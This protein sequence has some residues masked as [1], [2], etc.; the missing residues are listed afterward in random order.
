MVTLLPSTATR[1]ITITPA[2]VATTLTI[3]APASAIQGQLF[4]IEGQLRR[5]DTG[6][7]LEGENISLS[8]NGVNLGTTLTR[9]IEGS[10]KY[11]ATVKIDE[12]GTFTLKAAF[13]GGSGYAAS[14]AQTRLNVGD[15]IVSIP[16]LLVGVVAPILA[17]VL[18]AHM[19][20]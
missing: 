15:L 11:M 16:N 7:T 20:G 8:Y 17:G 18:I 12:S 2:D 6:V 13:A 9:Y 19:R 4:I 14:E 5:A 10:I 1:S 3:D